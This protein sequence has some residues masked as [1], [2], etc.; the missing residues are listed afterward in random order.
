M[1]KELFSRKKKVE[2]PVVEQAE[3]RVSLTDFY[4]AIGKSIKKVNK[5]VEFKRLFPRTINDINQVDSKGQQVA[6]DSSA[7]LSAGRFSNEIPVE[8]FRFLNE[9]FIGWQACA[10]LKQNP[11]IDKACSIP[12]K[13]AIS[14]DYGLSYIENNDKKED[15]D[16]VE[17]DQLTKIKTESEINYKINEVCAR[18]NVNKKVFGYSLVIPIVDGA[19]MTKPYNID[20]IKKGSYKGM[21]VVEPYWITPELDTE[22]MSDPTSKHY[23]EPTWYR[24]GNK[25]IHRSWVI[26]AINSEVSDILKPNYYFGGIPLT[27]Q[28]YERVYAAEKVA[29]EAPLLALTKRLLVVDADIQNMIANPEDVEETMTALNYLRDNFGVYAKNPNDQIQQLDTS[30]ADFDALIMTQYQLVASIAQMPAVKLLKTQPKGFNA[31]GEYEEHDYKQ[32]LVEIQQNDY[33]PIINRHNELYTKSE[34]G[35]VIP[36][37]VKF[38]PIDTPTK[39]EVAEV[40]EIKSRTDTN[41]INAGVLSQ[42][43]VRDVLRSE[44]NSVYSTIEEEAPIPDFDLSG[45]EDEDNNK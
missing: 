37:S 31:T 7:K 28:I 15:D 35:K 3:E 32:S 14:Q 1:L 29:N 30:L 5:D 22:S 17:E 34:Y 19:D 16:N 11:F 10:L 23:F 33:T 9:V 41:Y 43:E 42:N 38:N 24:I 27:Q 45:L 40:N 26:R 44:E 2:E 36:L 18:Q 20:G 12:A 39:K 8:M 21:K 6:M 4:K 13:D 25:R